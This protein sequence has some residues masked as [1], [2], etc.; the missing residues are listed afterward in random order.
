VAGRAVATVPLLLLSAVVT[1]GVWIFVPE[2][3][4]W[5][6]AAP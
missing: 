2:T 4:R 5:A 6:A 1:F 3:G